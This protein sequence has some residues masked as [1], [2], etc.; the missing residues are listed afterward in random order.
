M[1]SLF[2]FLTFLLISGRCK[3][4]AKKQFWNMLVHPNIEEKVV[5]YGFK[6]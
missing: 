2:L 6:E 4:T 3:I 5:K 1:Y